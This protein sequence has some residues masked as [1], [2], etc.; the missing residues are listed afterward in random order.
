VRSNTL[1][2]NP[3][4]AQRG[5]FLDNI[6]NPADLGRF[7]GAVQLFFNPVLRQRNMP[8][9]RNAVAAKA[10]FYAMQLA[11]IKGDDRAA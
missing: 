7:I 6:K 5:L 9:R 1:T 2:H 11:A 10:A 4:S 3:I 8:F